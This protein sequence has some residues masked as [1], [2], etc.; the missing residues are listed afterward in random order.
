MPARSTRTADSQSRRASQR[1]TPGLLDHRELHAPANLPTAVLRSVTFSPFIYRKM[2][3]RIDSS[4]RPGDLVA[5]RDKRNEHFG[6][7]LYNPRSEI[8]LRMLTHDRTPPDESWWHARLQQAVDL[9]RQLLRLDSVSDAYRVVH[10]EADGLTGLVADRLG[11]VLSIE[12]FS[13]GIYQRTPALA[14]VLS[15]A[16]G[17]AH[18]VIRVDDRVHGQEGFLADPFESV[19]LPRQWTVQEFGTRFRIRLNGTHKTGFFCDQRDNRRRLAELATDRSVLDLCCYSG[20]FAVQAKRLGSA[21][22]VIGVDLDERAIALAT[23][24][25]HLNQV[26]VSFVHADAFGY[27]RDLLRNRRQFDIVVLD[28][29]KLIRSRAEFAAGKRAH[30]DLNR[31][32][33]QAVR[34]GGLFVTCCCSGLLSE[35]EFRELVFAAARQPQPAADGVESLGTL[36]AVRELS[37]TGA[38][39]DHPVTPNCPETE[40]LKALWMSVL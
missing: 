15:A 9:R 16:C 28:P 24:N 30:F 35:A 12:V 21:S 32:A 8:T 13:V 31:L 5:V 38:A 22:E 14:R 29:P 40:Y 10:A 17:T 19:D 7:A 27:L 1:A 33:I 18:H 37:R 2:L 4:A 25:A 20:G 3:D 39:A 6:F 34:P 23:E 11:D 26:R 36:R